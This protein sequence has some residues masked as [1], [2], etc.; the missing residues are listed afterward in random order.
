[1]KKESYSPRKPQQKRSKDTK[2]ALLDA[3]LTLIASSGYHHINS[4][5]I[6][7]SAG[8]STGSFYAYFKDKKSLF[9][10]LV[11][12]YKTQTTMIGNLE[13]CDPS[14]SPLMYI[15]TF[16]LEKVTLAN[17]Y[18]S[19]FHRELHYQ[20]IRDKDIR[21][22]YDE[23]KAIELE[24][25]VQILTE[26]EPQLAV[27]SIKTA[28]HI[29]FNIYEEMITSILETPYE[30]EQANLIKEYSLLLARYLYSQ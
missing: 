11:R 4:K 21:A 18:P 20:I 30:L 17:K 24:V 12:T 25:I 2:K 29:I 23:Y 26:V 9:L 16:L 28:S 8:V 7:K 13:S 3:G 6:A 14:L 22:L 10:E 5:D 1:M 15:E 19:E 27:T